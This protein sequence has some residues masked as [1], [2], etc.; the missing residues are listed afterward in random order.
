MSLLVR[1]S[2]LDGLIWQTHPPP[3]PL[4]SAPNQWPRQAARRQLIGHRTV[5]NQTGPRQS[6][7]LA[8]GRSLDRIRPSAVRWWTS[9]AVTGRRAPGSMSDLEQALGA[10]S[11]R[12]LRRDAPLSTNEVRREAGGRARRA[13]GQFGSPAIAAGGATMR[14]SPAVGSAAASFK[15]PLQ[16]TGRW[17]DLPRAPFVAGQAAGRKLSRVGHRLNWPPP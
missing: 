6:L 13:G 15:W 14:C 8:V 16:S 3:K 12:W 2:L 1:S 17:P 5:S 10:R 11:G 4:A 9:A 7:Q